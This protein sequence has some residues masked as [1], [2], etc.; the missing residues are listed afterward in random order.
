MRYI[1]LQMIHIIYITLNIRLG[2]LRRP[3]PKYYVPPYCRDLDNNAQ[4]RRRRNR[5]PVTWNLA[6]LRNRETAMSHTLEDP[7]EFLL[8]F[9]KSSFV[10]STKIQNK[11]AKHLQ[12]SLPEIR[13][14]TDRPTAALSSKANDFLLL[15]IAHLVILAKT[16]K[17]LW[18]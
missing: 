14:H 6:C 7:I 1:N 13:H 4:R 16:Q 11:S 18:G 10:I 8:N 17:E 12:G 2:T 9:N 3:P 15:N 5:T